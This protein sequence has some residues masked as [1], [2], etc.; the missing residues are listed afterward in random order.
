MASYTFGK[1]LDYYSAQNLGQTPQNPYNERL[2]RARSDEDRSRVFSL[3]FV[4]EIP[5]LR[6]IMQS[7]DDV[8]LELESELGITRIEGATALATFHMGNP[9]VNGMNNNQGGAR[10]TW[11]GQAAYGMIERSSPAE[12]CTI[13][14]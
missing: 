9:G 4:Y 5:F 3:S 14:R 8:S 1:L 2:D 11:D 7:D 6:N 12:L 10:Y 13:V